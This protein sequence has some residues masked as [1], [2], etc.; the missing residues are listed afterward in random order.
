VLRSTWAEELENTYGKAALAW[1][2]DAAVKSRE[3]IMHLKTE[4]HK[5]YDSNCQVELQKTNIFA[6]LP[7]LPLPAELLPPSKWLVKEAYHALILARGADARAAVRNLVADAAMNCV[8]RRKGACR[9]EMGPMTVLRDSPAAMQALIEGLKK[10]EFNY[11]DQ[12]PLCLRQRAGAPKKALYKC[13]TKKTLKKELMGLANLL[14]VDL[15]VRGGP[16]W[17][18]AGH[19]KFV[20]VKFE[21]FGTHPFNLRVRACRLLR[22]RRLGSLPNGRGSSGSSNTSRDLSDSEVEFLASQPPAWEVEHL[23]PQGS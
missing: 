23:C 7:E 11:D 13:I 9:V 4:A 10:H 1:C 17:F 15:G 22:H 2:T 19:S 8:M 3:N 20:Q 21:A 5:L 12:E 6:L 16:V 18:R 14:D